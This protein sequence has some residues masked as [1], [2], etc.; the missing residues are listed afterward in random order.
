MGI[1]IQFDWERGTAKGK[2]ALSSV[3][4]QTLLGTWGYG[5]SRT[6]GGALHI[7]KA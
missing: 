3:G 1:Q 6:D 2:G 7:V 5:A 4:E